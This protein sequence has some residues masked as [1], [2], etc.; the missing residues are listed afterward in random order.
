M[1]RNDGT[2]VWSASHRPEDREFAVRLGNHWR[3]RFGRMRRFD[4]LRTGLPFDVAP[5]ESIEIGINPVA[6]DR[7]TWILELDMV[8]EHVRWFAEAG[9]QA[10]AGPR[11]RR[12]ALEAG[13]GRWAC[14]R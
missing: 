11:P 13:R 3:G 7:G 12:L 2:R 10:G 8:Q 6:P 4:D 9:S 14:R 1:I 5:G